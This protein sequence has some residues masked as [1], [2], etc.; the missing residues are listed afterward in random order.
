MNST[1]ARRGEIRVG[2]SGWRYPPWRG[3]FYPN[4]LPQRRELEYASR[5]VST[6]EING[7]FYS[8]QRPELYARWRDETPD[9]FLFSV[10]AP[11]YIT[12]MLRLRECDTALANFFASGIANLGDKLGPILWQLPPTFRFDRALLDDFLGKLP[13]DTDAASALAR[14]RNEK[15]K[16][17]ARLA[18]GA[19]RPLRHALEIRHETFVDEAFIEALRRQRVALVVADTAGKWPLAEDLT[20]DFVYARLHGDE[21]LYVSGYSDVALDAWASR[22]IAWSGGG[23]P[24]DAR[25]ISRIPSAACAGRD[26]FCYFDNDAKVMAPRDAQ[27]ITRIIHAAG[28]N[29]RLPRSTTGDDDGST[30][31]A[32]VE[33]IRGGRGGRARK[34]DIAGERAAG[35]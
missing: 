31:K 23:A 25:C 30:E 20:A 28:G 27:A 22:F 9:D 32:L 15:V 34:R 18:Y 26:V 19:C 21:V 6:I 33:D 17:R 29:V 8:L 14:R 24:D 2:I 10:K 16:G 7:S 11:R 3:T 5:H 35:R 4:G 13:R 12:H 1:V